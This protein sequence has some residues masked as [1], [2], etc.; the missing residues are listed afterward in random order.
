MT[1]KIVVTQEKYNQIFSIDEVFFPSEITTRELYAKMLKCV[2]G[3]DGQY[4]TEEQAREKFKEIPAA[5]LGDYIRAFYRAVGDG[6]VN[7]TS[8][9]S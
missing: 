5:E 9:N 2:V 1:I 4:L 8:G 7:P 6:L 3:D